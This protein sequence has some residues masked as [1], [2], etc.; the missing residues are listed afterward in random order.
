MS[1]KIRVLCVLTVLLL[2]CSVSSSFSVFAEGERV[3]EDA[4]F[5]ESVDGSTL[6]ANAIAYG[7]TT[8]KTLAKTGSDKVPLASN[9]VGAVET[10]SG[11][12]KFDVNAK[13]NYVNVTVP[14]NSDYVA[15]VY[16]KAGAEAIL[17][18]LNNTPAYTNFVFDRNMLIKDNETEV[19]YALDESENISAIYPET[20]YYVFILNLDLSDETAK[21]KNYGY[22]KI[23]TPAAPEI[24]EGY[25][26][27]M[28][29]TVDF[30]VVPGEESI[31][32]EP[33]NDDGYYVAEVIYGRS[34]EEM[35]SV[36]S[37]YPAGYL[38]VPAGHMI[39]EELFVSVIVDV[40]TGNTIEITPETEYL[41]VYY[42]MDNAEFP[43]N[44][45]SYGVKEINT[46]RSL[47]VYKDSDTVRVITDGDANGDDEINVKDATAIQKAVA[48]ISKIED[49]LLLKCANVNMDS[50]VDI[51]DATFIQ[52]YMAGYPLGENSIGEK[53][54]VKR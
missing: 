11:D 21:L 25:E 16:T 30:E 41:V 15:Y 34:I 42:K 6:P 9:P 52:K 44:I 3:Y 33:V 32:L 38:S 45:I 5:I 40:D 23:T 7:V 19:I 43:A 46:V 4:V 36:L 54:P 10:M 51:K 31:T 47:D 27:F 24:Y 35:E 14:D 29:N 50:K 28:S 2:L 18:T 20:E 1:R 39:T 12:V 26:G 22:Q 48:G 49:S 53:T 13:F 37:S 17:E 8:V